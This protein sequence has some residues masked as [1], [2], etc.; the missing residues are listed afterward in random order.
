MSLLMGIASV[1]GISI[2]NAELLA[3]RGRQ[4]NSILQ[5]LAASI[6][7]RDSLTA[8]HSEKVTE[9][10]QGICSELGL[11]RDYCEMIRV[12]SLL[13]D[14]GKIGV[15]DAILKKKG[16]LTAEEYEIVK[17][18]SE[19]TR[20]ILKQIHFEGIYCQVPDIAG[21]HHE[22]IDGN[23]YPQGLMGKDIPLG[24][25]IIAVADYFEAIT[26]KR[27]YRD[28][29][30]LE[31]AFLSLHEQIGKY[32]EKRIVEAF[33]AYYTKTFLYKPPESPKTSKQH[34]PRAPFR[35][36]VTESSAT[37]GMIED[38][39]PGIHIRVDHYVTKGAAG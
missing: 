11:S 29:M 10:A 13:H 26:A 39:R 37:S 22:R 20:K 17:T 2:Q 31:D 15:P 23:G 18:H 16:R 4:L 33:M 14:Y 19:K 12:A 28:P 7:A 6:D 36:E 3:A 27:H 38:S 34:W 30:K 25:R 35:A 1:I 5:V 32:F 21:A 8:G 9:Y 24:A